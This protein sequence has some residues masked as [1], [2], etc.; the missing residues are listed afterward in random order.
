M[1]EK[2]LRVLVY[3]LTGFFVLVFAGGASYIAS[4]AHHPEGSSLLWAA[5]FG[6][7]GLILALVIEIIILIVRPGKQPAVTVIRGQDE[8]KA[9][10][11]NMRNTQNGSL[12]L[13]IWSTNYDNVGDYF[14]REFQALTSRRDLRIHRLINPDVLDPEAMDSYWAQYDAYR[15]AGDDARYKHWQTDVKD[16]E[17]FIAVY[18][19]DNIQHLKS[20]FVYNDTPPGVLPLGLYIESERTPEAS[21]ASYAI[22][23]WFDGLVRRAEELRRPRN[24]GQQD[25]AAQG[26]LGV[27]EQLDQRA[28]GQDP[29]SSASPEPQEEND[30]SP[31]QDDGE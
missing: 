26:L 5:L 4:S 25:P 10:Y 13:A 21:E 14:K 30:E 18:H 22:K 28:R 6:F 3:V 2:K 1:S 7:S 15:E 17:C 20:L 27:P 31:G 12:M 24:L 16:F 29:G 11:A 23:A 19:K 8:L 9:K